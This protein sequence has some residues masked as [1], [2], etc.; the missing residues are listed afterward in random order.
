MKTKLLD[1]L[2]KLEEIFPVSDGYHH[3]ITRAT[4]EESGDGIQLALNVWVDGATNTVFLEDGDLEN[5]HPDELAKEIATIIRSNYEP[6]GST[7]TG[8]AAHSNPA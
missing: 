3:S 1:L 6:D 2:E 5:L 7:G 8:N 4:D